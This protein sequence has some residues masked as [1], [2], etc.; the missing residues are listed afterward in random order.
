MKK[1][2]VTFDPDTKTWEI[3]IKKV[4][5]GRYQV[6]YKEISGFPSEEK[7]K[8]EFDNAMKQFD[9]DMVILRKLAGVKYTFSSYVDY[10]F[11][12]IFLGYTENVSERVKLFL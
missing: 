7:A 5:K 10:W 1:P 12:N 8:A 3:I 4:N 11:Q 2:T 6:E 9:D